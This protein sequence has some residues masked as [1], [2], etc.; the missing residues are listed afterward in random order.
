[1]GDSNNSPTQKIYYFKVGEYLEA[2]QYI[3]LCTSHLY[4]R[5]PHSCMILVL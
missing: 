5:P 1:M 3:F 4:V 2:I